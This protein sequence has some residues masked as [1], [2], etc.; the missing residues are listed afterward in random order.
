MIPPDNMDF[1]INLSLWTS[2]TSFHLSKELSLIVRCLLFSLVTPELLSIT[3]R[4]QIFH[5]A[6]NR[7]ETR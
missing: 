4:I 7:T 5:H 2:N 3:W 1:K 6:E